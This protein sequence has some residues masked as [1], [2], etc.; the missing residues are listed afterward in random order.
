VYLIE[1]LIPTFDN[2]G[3]IRRDE[4]VLRSSTGDRL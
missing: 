2:D 3:E 4:I 1:F